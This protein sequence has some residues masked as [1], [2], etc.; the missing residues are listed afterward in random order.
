MAGTGP[1][2]RW[3]SVLPLPPSPDKPH[4][5]KKAGE[6]RSPN[7]VACGCTQLLKIR[8]LQAGSFKRI[9]FFFLRCGASLVAQL[10]KKLPASAGD[11]GSIPGSGRS[12][13]GGRGNLLQYSCLQ[14]PLDRGAWRGYSP[15]GCAESEM[16]V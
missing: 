7:P 15:R 9:F 14:N 5:V 16:T 2:L 10:V 6:T 12:P 1:L 3:P 4:R 11:P 8:L 13:G